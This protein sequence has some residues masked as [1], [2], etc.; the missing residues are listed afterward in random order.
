MGYNPAPQ[1]LARC[2]ASKAKIIAAPLQGSAGNG[3]FVVDMAGRVV[4]PALEG[5][6]GGNLQWNMTMPRTDLPALG[7]P[8]FMQR[9]V[10]NP[11]IYRLLRILLDK[12]MV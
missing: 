8:A 9:S 6:R 7:H 12:T 4:R 5:Q 2:A 1:S 11:M 10:Y 3:A